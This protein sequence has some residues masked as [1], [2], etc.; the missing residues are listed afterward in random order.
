[1]WNFVGKQNDIQGDY[2]NI[3]GNW[4][5]GVN[6]IDEIRLGNQ[7]NLDDDQKNNKARNTYFFFPFILGIIGLLYSYNRDLK[8]FWTLLLLFLFTG[9][10][11]KFYL[12]ERPFEPRERD[13]ALVGSFYVF[14]IWIGFGMSSILKFFSSLKNKYLN[15]GLFFLCLISV[16]GLMAFGNWDDHDRSDRYT[17]QSIARSYL[18]SI[19]KD[20]DAMIFTIGDNDTFALWYA[21]EIEEFRTDVRTI[22]TSLLATDWYI[23][24]MKRRAYISS[25]IPSQM[26][27]KN[28]AYGVRDYIRYENLLDTVRWDINNF[29]DWVSSDHPRTKYRNL[30]TQSG[31]DVSN[32]PINSLETVFYPTNKIR[33]PVNIDNVI[34]S[35]IVNE[36]DIDLIVPYIDIDLPESVLTKNQIM[37]LD[38]LANNNWERPIY[39]TG[40]SYADSEYIWMKEYLQLDGLVYKLVPIRTEMDKS[41]PYLMGRVD[42]ELMFEIVN[43]WSWGNSDGQNIYHDPETRKNSISFRSNMSRL[44]ET[45]IIEKKY[46]KA[47]HIIDLAFEKMPI[48]FYGYY[49]LWTPFV[50]SYY[51]IGN[52]NK[53]AE[54]IG[55]LSNKYTQRLNYF[56]SL[57]IY[58]QYNL[59]QEI[60]SEIERYRNLINVAIANEDYDIASDEIISFLDSSEPFSYLYGEFDYYL[61]LMDYVGALYKSNDYENSE[62]I[63]FEIKEQFEKRL[64]TF[65]TLPE[66]S[67]LYYIE[68][69]SSDINNYQKAINQIKRFDNN[70][71]DSL[72]S[73]FDN[74]IDR[75]VE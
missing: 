44:V 54:I 15:F 66:E 19:Q 12:N 2:S 6:F 60:V 74:L 36:R 14:S 48:E 25:P 58:Y 55:K 65:S 61:S 47:K 24:Q 45:L 23:D 68:N 40:G 17:A 62:K 11:L 5:S 59:T 32:Y 53:A 7:S 3:Y 30:I 33:V 69:I 75:M 26:E 57:D 18:Q 9:L 70:L 49:S 50:D 43:K 28:Y 52:K 37:M 56:E 51:Q 38:I 10:A 39:F 16:P 63:V 27:H 35:G 41:N 31:G 4:L 22:N 21:Q 67:Q 42:S 71:S 34:K 64:S 46:E 29:M 8:T 73:E 72:Q 1:M 20:K 13:Y